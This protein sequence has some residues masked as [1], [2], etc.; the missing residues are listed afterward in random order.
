MSCR[1]EYEAMKILD[2]NVA[3][4][5]DLGVD[6]KKTNSINHRGKNGEIELYENLRF[7]FIARYQ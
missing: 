7:H 4:C 2:E 1:Y 6:L 3:H 5:C